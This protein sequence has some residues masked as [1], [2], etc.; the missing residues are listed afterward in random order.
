MNSYARFLD[1]DMMSEIAESDGDDE[2]R[3][4]LIEET[5]GTS[6]DDRVTQLHTTKMFTKV[7]ISHNIGPHHDDC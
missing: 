4:V 7:E 6:V 5:D 1:M 2:E 3:M